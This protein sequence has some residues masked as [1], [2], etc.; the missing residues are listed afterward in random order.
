MAKK[1]SIEEVISAPVV[2]PFSIVANLT[3][4]FTG[5]LVSLAVG[6]G[7]AQRTLIIPFLDWNNHI[8]TVVA[9]WIV[10]VLT[11]VSVA[12]AAIDRLR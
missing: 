4:W 5:I 8:I 2:E 12:L 10:V 9:G 6:F 11:L 1:K 7:M 3:V